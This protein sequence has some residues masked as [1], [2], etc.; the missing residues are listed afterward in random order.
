MKQS[1]SIKFG[2]Y[3]MLIGLIHGYDLT[4]PALGHWNFRRTLICK[5][6]NNY[7]CIYDDINQSITENCDG[8][9]P[10][11]KGYEAVHRGNID[12]KSCT[13]ARYQPFTFSTV[14][15]SKCVFLKSVCNEEGQVTIRNG[16]A[17]EDRICGCDYQNLYAFIIKPSHLNNC[18]P[19]EEDCSCYKQLCPEEQRYLS[20]EYKCIDERDDYT[21]VH[22]DTAMWGTNVMSKENIHKDN[23]RKGDRSNIN[24]YTLSAISAGVIVYI[25]MYQCGNEIWNS[26]EQ[27][28]INCFI[29][30][31]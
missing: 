10:Y 24:R 26:I 2:I 25:G 22:P 30:K 14:W 7:T 17:T 1:S 3:M 9:V 21:T 23:S 20:K 8:P 4:C 29:S 13:D 18:K 16:L 5:E 11:G 6:I 12:R 27:R 28:Y 19:S 31:F 15:N